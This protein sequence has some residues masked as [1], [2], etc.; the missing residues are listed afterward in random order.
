MV[1]STKLF[2][3]S[4][5]LASPDQS[6]VHLPKGDAEGHHDGKHGVSDSKTQLSSN[7]GASKPIDQT[8]NGH[9]QSQLHWFV[10]LKKVEKH[11]VNQSSELSHQ[12]L[13][14]LLGVDLIRDL[15]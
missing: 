2:L 13:Q 1:N 11:Q 5:K 8:T 15:P 4:C 9:S 3:F 12:M 14:R 7:S 10:F 6:P